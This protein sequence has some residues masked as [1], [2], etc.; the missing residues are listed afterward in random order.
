MEPVLATFDGDPLDIVV[1]DDNQENADS[2]AQML[3]LA[4]HQVRIT[5]DGESCL[6]AVAERMP[7]LVLLDLGMPGLDGFSTCRR[8]REA[9][10][11]GLRILA[12][13]G[14]G[15]ARDVADAAKAGFD[16]HI[17]KPVDPA[18]LAEGMAGL[19][20]RNTA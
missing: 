10:G 8:I 16:G 14:W 12:V 19:G 5:Y 9:H 6:E 11:R 17:V 18:K 20:R 7:D 4:G 15:Q 1:T 3:R 13:T 2:L